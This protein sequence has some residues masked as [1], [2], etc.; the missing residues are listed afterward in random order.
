[1]DLAQFS[2]RDVYPLGASAAGAM[3]LAPGVYRTQFAYRASPQPHEALL[4]VKDQGQG[5]FLLVGVQKLG[6]QL[7]LAATYEFF[8]ADTDG[9]EDA[10]EL[11]FSMV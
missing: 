3:D 4:L 1:M 5:I 11:D 9:A 8:D 6:T 10:D 2:V 7:A